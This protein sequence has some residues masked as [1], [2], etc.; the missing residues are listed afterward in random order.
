LA[1]E[2]KEEEKEGIAGMN[3]MK[4]RSEEQKKTSLPFPLGSLLLPPFS[5]SCAS[6]ASLLIFYF[7]T[8]Q[9]L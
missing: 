7:A 2:E 4:R 5:S 9:P 1:S 6:C 3:R 8:F